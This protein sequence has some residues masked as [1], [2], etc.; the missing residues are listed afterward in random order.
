MGYLR[1][2]IWISQGF[3][4]D[5]IG[6]TGY[7][8]T[9]PTTATFDYRRVSFQHWAEHD[10]WVVESVIVQNGKS[11]GTRFMLTSSRY[12]EVRLATHHFPLATRLPIQ[13][14]YELIVFIMEHGK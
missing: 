11:N 1:D 5:T 7:T 8:G 13:V 9:K 14:G 2:M 10:W 12:E 4:R 3:T 6:I